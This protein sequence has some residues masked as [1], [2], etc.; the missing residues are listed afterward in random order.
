VATCRAWHASKKDPIRGMEESSCNS[1]QFVR[2]L[3]HF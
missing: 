1:W 2:I 3:W